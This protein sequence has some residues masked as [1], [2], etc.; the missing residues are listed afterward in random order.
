MYQHVTEPTRNRSLDC[1]HLL[2][3]VVTSNNIISEINYSSPLAKSDIS[4][5]KISVVIHIEAVQEQLKFN[6]NNGD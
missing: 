6:Y 1:P 5:L 2:N 3:L 4:V